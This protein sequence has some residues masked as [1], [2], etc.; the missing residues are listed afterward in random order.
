MTPAISTAAILP[1]GTSR[2]GYPPLELVTRPAVST[3][4]AAFYLNRMPQTLRMWARLQR[5]PLMPI[6][7]NKRLAWRTE[8]LK[9]VLGMTE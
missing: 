2:P 6:R 5:G 9:R 8:D 4:E 1:A 3:S 7:V